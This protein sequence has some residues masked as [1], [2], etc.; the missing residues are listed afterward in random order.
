MTL[1]LNIWH[2]LLEEESKRLNE[3]LQD[4]IQKAYEERKKRFAHVKQVLQ[5]NPNDLSIL[6]ELNCRNPAKD[7][8]E[9]LT[10]SLIQKKR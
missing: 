2:F 4:E 9:N 3:R 8:L 6:N 10:Q 1:N 5:A 7:L